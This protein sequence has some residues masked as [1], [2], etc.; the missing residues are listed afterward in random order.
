MTTFSDEEQR[1]VAPIQAQGTKRIPH[2]AHT[3]PWEYIHPGELTST[4]CPSL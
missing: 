4:S 1:F 3:A 2:A